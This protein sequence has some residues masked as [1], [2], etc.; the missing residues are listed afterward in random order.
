M[1]DN[2]RPQCSVS[3][4]VV[5]RLVRSNHGVRP[6][7]RP[8]GESSA[9]DA[10]GVDR[11]QF[12]RDPAA[13]RVAGQS[14]ASM[15]WASRNAATARARAFGLGSAASCGEPAETGHVDRHDVERRGQIGDDGHPGA[16]IGTERVQSTRGARDRLVRRQGPC[17]A[18]QPP[19]TNV[20][21]CDRR[22]SVDLTG[23]L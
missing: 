19:R 12:Q 4:W 9:I 20:T 17:A 14:G 3:Q 5:A 1:A 13:E 21:R 23:M 8:A 6:G 15:W 10:V 22:H 18:D 2:G 16:A 11:G 7:H